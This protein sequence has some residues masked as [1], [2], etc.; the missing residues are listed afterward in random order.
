MDIREKT[1]FDP[2]R[3]ARID[4]LLKRFVDE[5][6][7]VGASVKVARH[8]ETAYKGSAGFM[9]LEEKTPVKEDTLFRIFSMTKTFTSVALMTLFERGLVR[10]DDPLYK[11]LPEFRNMKVVGERGYLVDA[12]CP[13]TI[14]H[15]CAM[16]SGIP[17]PGDDNASAK[18]M[19]HIDDALDDSAT[20]LKMAKAAAAAPL[21]FHP[22]DHWLYGFSH[23][24]LGAV[25][26]VVS[27]KRYGEYLKEEVLD[28][29]GL[30]DTAFFV[31]QEK[32]S[33]LARAYAHNYETGANTILLPPDLKEVPFAP[34]A[35]E[36]GGGGLISSID[37]VSRFAQMLLNGGKLDGVRILSRKTVELIAANQL[38]AA[39][40]ADFN[41][42]SVTG[43]GYGLCVR[44]M[45]NPAEAG[46]NGSVG[47][48]AWD[49]MLGTWYAVDPKEDLTV[50]F[51]IQRLPPENGDH[52]KRL[53]QVVYG[54]LDD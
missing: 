49:G 12:A 2:K 14:R 44:T 22:G 45:L 40:K 28:P 23:D 15:L 48:F 9:N 26:E 8:G 46:T 19:K 25:I 34:P 16:T 43:Y 33:R 50:V 21:A 37:D 35:F 53:M 51:M 4:D 36:S 32:R 7:V 52:P 24:I 17:Y 42:D 38:N 13:I 29:L 30:T 27:G 1:G 41:W 31:P 18:A 11:F 47:E 6:E 10:L 39:Q 5:G 20:T 3:L 54:A